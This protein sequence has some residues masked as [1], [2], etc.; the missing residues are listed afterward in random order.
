MREI[1]IIDI[2]LDSFF[3]ELSVKLKLVEETQDWFFSWASK[4]VVSKKI[5]LT[6]LLEIKSHV[7]NSYFYPYSLNTLGTHHPNTGLSKKIQLL[8]IQE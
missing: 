1:K 5:P 7:C 4:G 2:L 8:S 6:H 3:V